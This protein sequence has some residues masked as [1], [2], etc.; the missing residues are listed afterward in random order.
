MVKATLLSFPYACDDTG[1]TPALA[2]RIRS[3][4]EPIVAHRGAR[5]ASHDDVTLTCLN[6]LARLRSGKPLKAKQK[7]LHEHRLVAVRRSLRDELEAAVL[8][9]HDWPDQQP[10]PADHRAAASEARAE[11]P[12]CAH[13]GLTR[14]RRSE[15]SGAVTRP[16]PKG[17]E[18]ESGQ[19]LAGGVRQVNRPGSAAAAQREG[20]RAE[21]RHV[22]PPQAGHDALSGLA[23]SVRNAHALAWSSSMES[24]RQADD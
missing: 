12:A 6:V 1:L 24:A 21:S 17:R 15:P 22:K 18:R 19:A 16:P 20:M 8:Q 4:A 13:R 11:R 10:A 7:M 2:D 3:P 5:Q 9:G 14:G 23:E